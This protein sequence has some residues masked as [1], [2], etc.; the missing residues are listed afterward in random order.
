VSFAFKEDSTSPGVVVSSLKD[1][2]V[3]ASVVR[4]GTKFSKGKQVVCSVYANNLDSAVS[5]LSES[6]L[7]NVPVSTNP[8][9]TLRNALKK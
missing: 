9:D 1:G 4:Y 6:F 7:A 5:K 8:I 2:R 3:Y